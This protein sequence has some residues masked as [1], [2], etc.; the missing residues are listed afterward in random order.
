MGSGGMGGGMGGVSNMGVGMG[1]GMGGGMNFARQMGND[2][3][4][5]DLGGPSSLDLRQLSG[6]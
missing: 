2:P 4:F 6:A 5:H 3:G 1:G